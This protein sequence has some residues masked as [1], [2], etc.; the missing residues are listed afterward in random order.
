MLETRQIPESSFQ[1]ATKKNEYY[2]PLNVYLLPLERKIT[3][4]ITDFS[5]AKTTLLNLRCGGH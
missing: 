2:L 5:S 4:W 1:C 3:H